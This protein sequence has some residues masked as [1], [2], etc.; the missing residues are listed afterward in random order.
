MFCILTAVNPTFS[1][2]CIKT[3]VLAL[4]FLSHHTQHDVPGVHAHPSGTSA[5]DQGFIIHGGFTF[6]EWKKVTKDLIRC[7]KTIKNLCLGNG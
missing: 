6:K 2:P 3:E 1:P 4:L 7:S 5:L